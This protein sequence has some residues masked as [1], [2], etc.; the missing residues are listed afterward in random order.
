M[1]ATGCFSCNPI[2]RRG[3]MWGAGR[4]QHPGSH[5]GGEVVACQAGQNQNR[6][7]ILFYSLDTKA[8]L[9]SHF[10]SSCLAAVLCRQGRKAGHSNI[11][12]SLSCVVALVSLLLNISFL[13]MRYREEGMLAMPRA[14]SWTKQVPATSVELSPLLH[15]SGCPD[16]ILAVLPFGLVCFVVGAP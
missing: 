7:Q 10:P 13:S 9:C 15:L 14:E 16:T 3:E 6:A 4:A 5:T 12:G 2:E 11:P 8:F 1:R